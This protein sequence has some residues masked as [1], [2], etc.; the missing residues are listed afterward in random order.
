MQFSLS[1]ASKDGNTEGNLEWTGISP[2]VSTL[3]IT[4]VDVPLTESTGS[5]EVDLADP[6]LI[7]FDAGAA[8]V[9]TAVVAT[10]VADFQSDGFTGDIQVAAY[11][12]PEY[13]LNFFF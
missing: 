10:D 2:E 8:S 1:L 11:S 9:G 3:S 7:E 5:A 4:G 13:L 12:L 6:V